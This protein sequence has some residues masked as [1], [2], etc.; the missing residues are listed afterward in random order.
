MKESSVSRIICR[1]GN[2]GKR[3][4]AS[5]K[6][7]YTKATGIIKQYDLEGNLINQYAS[8]AEAAKSC[9]RKDPSN[10]NACCRGTQK[11]AYGY[12]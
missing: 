1:T 12:K 2:S 7:K 11:T 10:I 8:A 5:S 6:G 3:Q 9:G 4:R